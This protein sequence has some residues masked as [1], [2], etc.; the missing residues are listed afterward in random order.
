VVEPAKTLPR[1]GFVGFLNRLDFFGKSFGKF[2]FGSLVKFS[3]KDF[4]L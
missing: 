2:W 4:G 3:C 1:H